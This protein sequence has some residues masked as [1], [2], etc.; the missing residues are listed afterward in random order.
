MS[1]FPRVVASV[2]VAAVL[3]MSACGVNGPDTRTVTSSDDRPAAPT[4]EPARLVAFGHSYVAGLGA[5]RGDRAWPAVVAARTCRPLVNRAGSGDI[6]AETEV[7]VLNAASSLQPRDVVVVETGI[8]DV[9][10]FGAD[11]DRL[12]RYGQRIRGILSTLQDVGRGVPVVLVADPGIAET[13]WDDY[14]PYDRGSQAVADAYAD[15]LREVAADFPDATVVDVREAWSGAHIHADGVHPNDEGHALIAEAVESALRSQGLDRCRPVRRLDIEGPSL[16]TTPYSSTRFSATF[17]P[18]RSLHQALWSVTEPDGS[19]TDKA[20]IDEDGVLTVNHRDGDVVVTA[21]AADGGG[22]RA[23]VTVHLRLDPS[24]VRGN[25][26]RWPG[27]NVTV[28]SEYSPNY[29][30]EKVRDGIIGQPDRGDWASAGERNPWVQLSW[31]RPIQADRVVLYDRAGVDDVNGG[32]LTFSDGT[33]VVVTD[34]PPNGDP[35]A[36]TFERKTV[37]WVRFQVEHGTGPNSGLAEFEVDAIPTPPE[38]PTRVSAEPGAG[39]VTVTWEP[40]PFDGGTPVTGYVVTPFRGGT[41]LEPVTVD[42]KTTRV[43]VS[44]LAPGQAYTFTV[45]ATNLVGTG[46]ASPATDPVIPE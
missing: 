8:N 19:P 7:H 39:E 45:A 38:A 31:D 21:T 1:R 44:G 26:A 11:G 22:A 37:T 18:R 12:H 15:K 43:V 36:V 5:S 23:S 3:S 16:I 40:P 30:G 46:P 10:A 9:R 20:V 2:A 13:A 27:A 32:T 41:P 24:L 17:T 28:S 34:I 42:E 33:F 35:K 4:R 14:P 6:A 25:A 29:S